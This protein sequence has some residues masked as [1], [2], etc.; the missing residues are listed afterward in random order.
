MRSE[1]RR[2]GSDLEA[3]TCGF[4]HLDMKDRN[5]SRRLDLWK[6]VRPT[7]KESGI[8]T[9]HSLN[10]RQMAHTDPHSESQHET[11]ASCF[12]RP[13]PNYSHSSTAASAPLPLPLEGSN[14]V[15]QLVAHHSLIIPPKVGRTCRSTAS[16]RR[17]H[18]MV[19]SRGGLDSCM[20]VTSVSSPV[21]DVLAHCL[22]LRSW[23]RLSFDEAWLS[24]VSGI[25]RHC[26]GTVWCFW[27]QPSAWSRDGTLR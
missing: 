14:V 25:R 1:Y 20:D 4:K 21:R 22:C 10:D 19:R 8:L 9:M 13:R 15:C 6:S 27:W 16:C 18:V 3:T 24:R 11:R 17:L 23:S 5:M 12:M 7:F 26:S 2:R